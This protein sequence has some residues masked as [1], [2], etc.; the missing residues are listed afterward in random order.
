MKSNTLPRL[1]GN[2]LLGTCL[3]A[4]LFK[5]NTNYISKK[6]GFVTNVNLTSRPE[7]H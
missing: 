7:K 1:D 6:V 5:P 2:D 4:T 3:L